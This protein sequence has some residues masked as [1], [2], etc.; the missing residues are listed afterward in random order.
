[1]RTG[2]IIVVSHDPIPGIVDY[3]EKGIRDSIK[4]G[5][6]HSFGPRFD[7]YETTVGILEFDISIVDGLY[8]RDQIR[9]VLSFKVKYGDLLDG[10]CLSIY[11]IQGEHE[12]GIIEVEDKDT[13]DYIAEVC[14]DLQLGDTIT[15]DVTATVEHDLF[16]PDQTS[17]SGFVIDRSSDWEGAIEFYD[18]TDPAYAPK[19]TIIDIYSDLDKDGI[20][21]V[22]DNCPEDSNPD[23]MDRDGDGKGDA[24]D[25]CPILRIFGEGSEVVQLLR[26][27]RNSVLS[28]TGEGQDGQ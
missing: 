2:I 18:H 12:N 22:D 25:A 7:R 24:C 1:M 14:E 3:S 21:Y 27:F 20:P 9:A 19:L 16:D 17:F 10:R 4:V 5:Y 8:T 15:L 28:Q 11:S 23:Q 26:D 6:E 13:G